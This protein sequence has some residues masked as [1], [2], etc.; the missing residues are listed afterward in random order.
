[1]RLRQNAFRKFSER[2]VPK[3]PRE[4][5]PAFQRW[6]RGQAAQSP[7]GTREPQ[8]STNDAG[9]SLLSSLRDSC[10]RLAQTQRMNRWAI[11][12]C[13]SG[14]GCRASESPKC[15]RIRQNE[16]PVGRRD[17][18]S[19]K[20]LIAMTCASKLN[21]QY[22][23]HC[24]CKDILRL[25]VLDCE[26]RNSPKTVLDP[27]FD[28]VSYPVRQSGFCVIAQHCVGTIILEGATASNPGVLTPTIRTNPMSWTKFAPTSPIT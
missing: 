14:T 25:R 22:G 6:V 16:Q 1:M 26:S 23:A 20:E 5:S 12:V 8:R 2:F 3:G 9:M 18:F 27:N 17:R 11:T 28:V 7:A 13:P 19:K 21:R 15:V 10:R 24:V 4:N